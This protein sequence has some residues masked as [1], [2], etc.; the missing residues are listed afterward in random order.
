MKI[1]FIRLENFRNAEFADVQLDTQN[2]WIYGQ[3]AQGKTNLLEATGLLH[4]LR[5]FRTSE[6]SA[7][8]R[9][10]EKS[11]RILAGISHET[12]GECE[13]MISI[14]DKRKAYIGDE[15][16]KFSDFIGKFPALAMSNAD[17]AL[18]RGSPEL[19]RKDSDMFISS[20]DA[21]YFSALKTY[22]GA[23]AQR[24][25]LLRIASQNIAEYLPFETQM[26]ESA[27]VIISKRREK[28]G[29]LGELASQKYAIL[30]KEN[31]ENAEIKIKPNCDIQD[32]ED[33]LKVLDQS[34]NK[35]IER[36]S[37]SHGPHRD[38]FKILIAN[39]DAKIYASEG[40][41]RSAVI[42]LKLA[43]FEA[44]KIAKNIVPV[45]LCDDILGELDAV[46]RHAFWS[47]IDEQSQ[48]IA[49]STESAPNVDNRGTWKTILVN[50]GTFSEQ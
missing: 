39:K 3:N 23:L 4:A 45:I 31:G 15:E 42:A 46:R 24:N 22:H 10:G 30:A 8:I 21:E 9:Y 5:S 28:L 25:A 37:T 20:I 7:M 50:G 34:R 43:Q 40:Q 49:T 44:I 14:S 11:A 36:R 29:E 17:I 33:F 26:A 18:L 1:K 48:V 32:T 13:V 47:C 2:V 27:N 6:M 19:R 38:D 41:Q 12:F 35:D 16:I